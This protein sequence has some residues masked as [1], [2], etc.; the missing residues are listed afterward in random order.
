MQFYCL[1]K[2]S[3]ADSC[4]EDRIKSSGGFGVVVE[5]RQTPVSETVEEVNGWLRGCCGD[6][7]SGRVP[8]SGARERRWR[9]LE[10]VDGAGTIGQVRGCGTG[11]REWPSVWGADK[12]RAR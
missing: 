9:A 8:R 10:G 3:T 6:V 7:S 4:G 5:M 1:L 12:P 11:A 2:Q